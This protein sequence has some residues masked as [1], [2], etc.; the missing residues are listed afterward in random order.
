MKRRM[1]LGLAG[2]TLCSCGEK[3]GDQ[4]WKGI[5]FGIPVGIRFRN[6]KAEV[7]EGLGQE[8]L[9]LAQ[10]YEKS[11]S[12]WDENS[13][14]SRLNRVGELLSPSEALL[15]CL[16]IAKGFYETGDGLFDPT[17]QSYLEWARAEYSAGRVP[18]SGQ[19]EE[20]R[21]LVDFSMVE[22]SKERV[23]LRDGMQ[24]SL[25]A[26]AQGYVTDRVSEFLATKVHQS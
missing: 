5:V 18:D 11:F 15:E 8:A 20:K 16:T 9:E 21:K 14:L 22:I 23:G 3:S 7:A 19:A 13:E 10:K 12:L 6:V 26:L 2:G 4:F 17:I 1:F 25:N 24:L